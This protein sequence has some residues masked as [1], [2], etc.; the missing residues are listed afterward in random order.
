[1]SKIGISEINKSSFVD[2]LNVKIDQKLPLNL[3]MENYLE[4]IKN[5]YCF[6]CGG[7]AVRVRYERE[8]A[9]LRNKLKNY[10]INIKNY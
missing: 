7:S 2:I 6:L 10:Y 4:H 1:M 3:R 5:P 8:G 9:D